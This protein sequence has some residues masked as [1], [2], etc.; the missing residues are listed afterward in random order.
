MAEARLQPPRLLSVNVGRP[1]A[2]DTGRRT[3]STAIW[4]RPVDGP[5]RGARR[6][7]R[8]RRPGRPHGP[9][10]AGQGGLRVRD[11]G[12]PRVGGRARPRARTRR[13]RR[14]PHDRGARRLGCG[15][16]R[17][18]AGRHDAARGRPAAAAVLQARAADGGPEVRQALRGG[19]AARR[20]PADHRGGRARRRRRVEVDS[21]LPDH[22]VTVRLVSDA[23]L[24]D[25][26][27]APQVLEAPQLL[28]SLR[29]L[30]SGRGAGAA[31]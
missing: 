21:A 12:D 11:R 17:A 28:P 14:E 3:V 25:P 24:L 5:G 27:L 16:R 26:G 19:L 1:R 10:R 9:R 29:E 23:I 4:K 8:R 20:L 7:P 13:V 18:L 15:A 2:V 30:L 22:G 31:G 6:E